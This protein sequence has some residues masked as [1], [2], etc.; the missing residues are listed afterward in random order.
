MPAPYRLLAFDLDGTLLDTIGDIAHYANE[1]LRV[2]GHAPQPVDR[3]RRSV[4]WGVHELLSL[5]APPIGADRGRLEEA[6]EHF[7]RAYR[8]HPVR[9]TEPFPGVREVLAEARRIAD[10][11]IVTNKP[12]DITRRIL[13]ELKMDHLFRRVIGIHAGFA[14]K[15]DPSGLLDVIRTGKASILETVYVGD[16]RVD[17]ET[18]KAAG[19]SFAW[20][21]YG[22]DDEPGPSAEHRF[23]RAEEWRV[24]F[25]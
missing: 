23:D 14:P 12:E 9:H 4:G 22:Y 10:L 5:L 19:V 20:V 7:K 8:A 2:Y 3:I 21:S 13:S 18:A 16:S 15:P 17:A 25:S 6:V 1:T 24:L 11:A